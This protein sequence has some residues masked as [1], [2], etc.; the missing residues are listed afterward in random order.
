M[1]RAQPLLRAI[2][3]GTVEPCRP[4]AE[5]RRRLGLPRVCKSALGK[6]DPILARVCHRDPG[7]VVVVVAHAP[8]AT[9]PRT[10]P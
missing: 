3:E 6:V 8:V 2:R 10:V 9:R 5:K 7:A 1:F 4:P